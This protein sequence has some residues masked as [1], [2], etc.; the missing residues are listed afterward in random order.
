MLVKEFKNV[1]KMYSD[2]KTNWDKKKGDWEDIAHFVGITLDTNF[3]NNKGAQ[4]DNS[5][6]LD[7]YVDDPTSAISVNQAG[8][9]L[10]GVMWGTGEKV[11]EIH[12]SRHVTELVDAAV[13]Q[14]WYK[15]ATEQTLFHMNH[16]DAGFSTALRPYTYDQFSFGT[17]GVG[18]FKNKAFEEAVEENALIFRDF[19]VDNT[20][21]DEG[22]SGQPEIVFTVYNWKISRI[23][24]EFC[25]TGGAV[26]EKKLKKLPKPMREAY[27]NNNF[28]EYFQIVFGFFPRDDYNPKL[29]GKKGTRYRGVWFL[30]DEHNGKPFFEEDFANRPIAMA[31]AI[32]VRG[33]TYGRASGTLLISTIRSVNFMV[34]TA[35]EIVD[36]MSRPPVGVMNNAIFGD[37]VLDTSPNGM[38]IFNQALAGATGGNPVFPLVDVGDPSSIL[39]FLVPYLNEKIVTAFKVDALLDFSSAKE[40]TA[41]ESLQRFAIRGKS[42]AGFLLQQKNEFLV[43]MAKRSINVLNSVGELGIDPNKDKEHTQFLNESGKSERLIP[44]QVLDVMESGKPWFELKFNNELE[45]L[46]RTENVQALIQMI[47]A[48]TA[49]AALYPQIAMAIDW[50]KMLKD[51]NDNLDYNSQIL[52][53]EKKFKEEILKAAEAQRQAMA[54]QAGEAGAKIN[55]DTAQAKKTNRDAERSE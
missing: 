45:K 4:A 35:I 51:I 11:F 46:V 26:D 8:D 55:K 30:D 42:L 29:K 6:S 40:M 15:Y 48:V 54:L 47:Q 21:M 1:Q 37:S 16:E 22:K 52:I 49:I 20:M 13:V 5:R 17:S 39:N 44:Q 7:E 32:K 14:D 41:T 25:K 18:C 43:P 36:K 9:Y 31:R 28:N 33:E 38:T 19:G 27:A 12:P 53:S 34:G 10:M 24:A 3:I 23:L 2:L 50:Y